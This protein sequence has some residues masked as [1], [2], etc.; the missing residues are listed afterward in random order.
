M[1][2]PYQSALL[3]FLIGLF[4]V[5]TN[6][7]AQ[8]SL[9][10]S[11]DTNRL[12]NSATQPSLISADTFVPTP[13]RFWRASG[14]LM[15]AQV[16][17]WSYNYFVR[18]ADF[19]KISFKSIGHNLKFSNWVWDDNS[20]NTNQFAHPYHGGIYFSSFRTNGYN[21]WQSVPAAF[22]G[23]YMWEVAGETHPPAPNDFIN[24]SMGG[25]ALGEM[26][27]RLSNMIVDNRQTGTRR[28]INEV[29]AFLVN[30]MNGFNRL[31]D[32][33]W[34]RV[35]PNSPDRRPGVFY[36]EFDLGSRRY[37]EKAKDNVITKGRNEW[38]F[39]LRLQYGDPFKEMQKPFSNFAVTIEAGDNDT[40]KINTLRVNGFLYGWQLGDSN[41]RKMHVAQLTLNFDYYRNSAF[42]FGGQ[43]IN[44]GI[45]SKFKTGKRTTILTYV[46]A[47]ALLLGAVP[48]E[49]LYYGEGRNYN[50][51]P[52]FNLIADA[53]LYISN[54][55]L[56]ATHY[57]GGWFGT[58]NGN[59]S[60]FFL[61]NVSSELRYFVARNISIGGEWGHN[62]LRGNYKN[63]PDV[64]KTFPYLRLSMGYKFGL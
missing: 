50:Y 36:G 12:T 10:I 40:S 58:I 1:R 42:F 60:H 38:F 13:K 62:T 9:A 8:D 4:F 26:T 44:F 24:T 49:Y 51:G 33:K 3:L 46:G 57:R 29:L 2:I 21:F 56:M 52:G 14:E 20:F 48:D 16:I 55:L 41:A 5:N 43:S 17:P 39:K 7:Q 45:N 11:S 6:T 31:I 19:A 35:M 61:N 25:I 22:A 27:Y 64:D 34:G 37:S 15:L 54:K 28:Q 23:S 63:F 30:P 47:G 59:S 53:T 18:K 32:G